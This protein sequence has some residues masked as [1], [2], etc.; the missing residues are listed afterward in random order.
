MKKTTK[1]RKEPAPS[2]GSRRRRSRSADA[3]SPR[4]RKRYRRSGSRSRERKRGTQ[5]SGVVI[6]GMPPQSV[7]DYERDI[8]LYEYYKQK[9]EQ[10]WLRSRISPPSPFKRF[11]NYNPTKVPPPSN[12]PTQVQRDVPSHS[13][14]VIPIQ[15]HANLPYSQPPPPGDATPTE[16][17]AGLYAFRAPT[18]PD[19]YFMPP[20]PTPWDPPHF[21]GD[22]AERARILQEEEYYNQMQNKL[23]GE[24]AWGRGRFPEPYD[25]RGHFER[26]SGDRHDSDRRRRGFSP[27]DRGRSWERDADRYH[28]RQRR[29]EN[30]TARGRRS[31][32]EREHDSRSRRREESQRESRSSRQESSRTKK[33][34][35]EHSDDTSS[36]P[37][38]RRSRRDRDTKKSI[39][40]DRRIS[41]EPYP[42]GEGD[43]TPVRDESRVEFMTER[44]KVKVINEK[45][46]TKEEK[47]SRKS[48]DGRGKETSKRSEKSRSTR[49]D[50]ERRVVKSRDTP[51][52]V[53]VTKSES[54]PSPER[55]PTPTLDEEADDA[56]PTDQPPLRES[57]NDVPESK[58][59]HKQA[60]TES[61]EKVPKQDDERMTAKRPRPAEGKKVV[62]K[63][64]VKVKQTKDGHK[65]Q[66]HSKES[67]KAATGRAMPMPK[68]K[69][70]S[71]EEAHRKKSMIASDKPEQK[72]EKTFIGAPIKSRKIRIK[73]PGGSSANPPTV[74]IPEV[75][76]DTE[77]KTEDNGKKKSSPPISSD[78]RRVVVSSAPKSAVEPPSPQPTT[79]TP[80]VLRQSTSHI[81][82]ASFEPDYN[83]NESEKALSN[84]A[85][86]DI[87]D[88]NI[89]EKIEKSDN[90]PEIVSSE[91]NK[92]PHKRRKTEVVEVDIKSDISEESE[93]SQLSL[94]HI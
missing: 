66:I 29:S 43:G 35:H 21:D 65:R 84:Y 16:E 26:R 89:A 86:S 91:E 92:K 37:S 14:H 90:E 4:R 85:P 55:S 52:R 31:S 22:L 15:P 2:G 82:E 41:D 23:H 68:S 88:N 9:Y 50:P 61:N 83:D 3:D 24:R 81:D 57:K 51:S 64:K 63:T 19:N 67:S 28:S 54:K 18:P 11:I 75:S 93:E 72:S 77:L 94:I 73:K 79:K 17:D 12:H 71:D 47:R 8:A 53:E 38:S 46:K 34:A 1:R 76:K 44:I 5:K 80:R 49:Q 13:T 42:P 10:D 58:I 39:T 48:S 6:P 56:I 7:L 27:R 62:R 20:G 74:K 36:R 87:D 69:W 32:R 45:V 40:P 78:S 59:V 33:R 25:Q 60:R 30:E 70:D